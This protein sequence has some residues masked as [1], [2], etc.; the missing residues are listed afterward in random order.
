MQNTSIMLLKGKQ[1]QNVVAGK[2]V[3]E[4]AEHALSKALV[5]ASWYSII[6]MIFSA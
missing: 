2:L 1:E 6:I 3:Y 5:W 4:D